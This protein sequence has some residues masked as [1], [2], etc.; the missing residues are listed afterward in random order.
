MVWKKVFHG[1]GKFYGATGL[2]GGGCGGYWRRWVM[3]WWRAGWGGGGG[4]GEVEVAH[5]VA[6]V[7]GEGGG[8]GDGLAG[9]G[10]GEA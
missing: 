7:A 3:A 9:V 8:G 1:V 6:E 4:P 2:R 5:P 10:V